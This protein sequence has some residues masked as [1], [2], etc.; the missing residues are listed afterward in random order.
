MW[1]GPPSISRKMQCLGFRRMMRF[2]TADIRRTRF[3]LRQHRRKRDRAQ[4]HAALIEKL[5]TARSDG[6]N[7]WL[8]RVLPQ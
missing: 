2:P 5:P 1:L 7:G 3:L 6:L 4:A 8:H